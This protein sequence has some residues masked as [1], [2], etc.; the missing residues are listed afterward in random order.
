V[1][2]KKKKKRK[3]EEKRG[4]KARHPAYMDVSA[5]VTF[6][7][8]LQLKLAVCVGKLP[9]LAHQVMKQVGACVVHALQKGYDSKD[10]EKSLARQVR[11]F[12]LLEIRHRCCAPVPALGD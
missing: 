3:K 10:Y 9:V 6:L 1:P 5:K 11:K 7:G 12:M 4:K 8:Q 2:A